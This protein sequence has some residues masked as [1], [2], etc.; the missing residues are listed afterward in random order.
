MKIEC[1]KCDQDYIVDGQ[2]LP[3]SACAAFGVHC[4]ECG[5]DFKIGRYPETEIR[6]DGL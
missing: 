1:P 2:D 3:S 6:D 5:H 4:E